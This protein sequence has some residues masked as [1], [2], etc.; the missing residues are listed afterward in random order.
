MTWIRPHPL[1]GLVLAA[2]SLPVMALAQA[3]RQGTQPRAALDTVVRVAQQ[4]RH[5]GVA[6]LIEEQSIGVA[7]GAEEYMLGEISDIAL[8]RDGSLYV[9]DRQVPTIRQYDAQGKFLRTIG[10][11]GAGPG[12]YRSASGL[13]AM[14][15]GRLLLWDTGNWR[16]NVYSAKGDV[17]TQW[18]TPSGMSGGGTAMYSRAIMVDTSGWVITRKTIFDVRD[19]MNR[20][21]IWLRYRPDGTPMDTIH[22]PASPR[23]MGN[24]SAS[25]ERSRV[26]DEVP[27][28]PKRIVVMSPLGYLIA[29]Y[30]DRYAFE[31]HEPGRPVVSVRRDVKAAPVSRAERAEARRKSE[32]RMRRT[33][34]TWS[35]NGPEI[36]DVKPL[37]A[38]IQVGLD[39]R[40]WV[41]VIP[42]VSPRVGNSSGGGGVGPSGRRPP[43]QLESGEP[44]RPALYDVFEPDGPYIGQVQVPAR[45]S[46][47]VRRGDQ[48]WGIAWDADD[49]PRIKRYRIAW[50]R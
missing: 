50:K 23:V 43:P 40:I 13:A 15:D 16:I 18:T 49:V 4:P 44:P 25:T 48:V 1:H 29:G 35:W 8:G 37:Y 41:A 38:D 9:F 24:L 20:P 26:T 42:E 31:I 45:V 12:E 6:T 21:T 47:V 39:G 17:L 10:R 11:R 19:I 34:P 2:L 3:T 5:P 22:A 28:A 36:P 27:F 30:P 32:E 46:S 33:D 14:P 7:D